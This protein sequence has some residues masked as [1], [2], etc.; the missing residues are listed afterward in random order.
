MPIICLLP[1]FACFVEADFP[2]SRPTGQTAIWTPQVIYLLGIMVA[3][4]A[5][6]SLSLSAQCSRRTMTMTIAVLGYAPV[7]T[8]KAQEVRI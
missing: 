2:S 3:A 4:R 8:E 6:H 7:L 1:L 5:N